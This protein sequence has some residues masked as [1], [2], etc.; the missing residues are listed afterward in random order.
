MKTEKYIVPALI[1]LTIGIECG[2]ALSTEGFDKDDETD[3]G[4]Q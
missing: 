1:P 2:F 3:A 4:W